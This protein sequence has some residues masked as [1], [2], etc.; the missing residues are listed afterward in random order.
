MAGFLTVAEGG[1]TYIVR[2]PRYSLKNWQPLFWQKASTLAIVGSMID[3]GIIHGSIDYATSYEVVIVKNKQNIRQ[4]F[5]WTM[6]RLS[7]FMILSDPWRWKKK[8]GRSFVKWILPMMRKNFIILYVKLV[9]ALWC[10]GQDK[11]QRYRKHTV[12]FRT[13]RKSLWRWR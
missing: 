2:A 8:Q 4:A 3:G 7:G 11:K 1:S 12:K 13:W 10:T 6:S 5:F 9:L